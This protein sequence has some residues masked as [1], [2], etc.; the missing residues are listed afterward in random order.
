MKW[1]TIFTA[2][3]LTLGWSVF[4]YAETYTFQQGQ[5]DSNHSGLGVYEGGEDLTI[6]NGS[7]TW[8]ENNPDL[9]RL[10]YSTGS[11]YYNSLLRFGDL[12]TALQG[13]PI[14]KATLYM[15]FQTDI[16][17]WSPAHIDIYPVLKAWSDPNATWEYADAGTEY[18][19]EQAGAQ[20]ASDRGDLAASEY[21]G[22]RSGY[23]LWIQYPDGEHVPEDGFSLPVELVRHWA[24]VPEENY[25]LILTMNPGTQSDLVYSSHDHADA[26]S[27][28]LLVI[29]TCARIPSDLTLD[30]YVD[31]LDYS[32]L[33]GEWKRDTDV[34]MDLNGDG[35]I[36]LLDLLL[37][38]EQW[39]RCSHPEDV[40]C[41]WLSEPE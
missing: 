23:P 31:L 41:D 11:E 26:D 27:R 12:D 4:A 16:V 40:S 8:P 3:M 2:V 38:S 29:E 19:W 1:R 28:P 22:N 39:L 33:A 35:T 10:L 37:F 36:D 32:L 30:C 6:A 25:G 7:T 21:L 9:L 24:N 34:T 14:Y 20:G 17:A 15:T 18:A 13:K 5:V